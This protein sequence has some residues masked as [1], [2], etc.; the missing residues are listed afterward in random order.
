MGCAK[1]DDFPRKAWR[2]FGKSLT[3]LPYSGFLG[4]GI[5]TNEYFKFLG[6]KIISGEYNTANID[7]LQKIS[8]SKIAPDGHSFSERDW[9][10]IARLVQKKNLFTALT[11][12]A[13]Y[14]GQVDNPRKLRICG[15][16]HLESALEKH[17]AEIGVA[18]FV[19]FEGFVQTDVIAKFLA[20]SLALILP[21]TEEQFGNVVIEAQAMGLPVLISQVCGARDLLVRNWVNGFVFEPDNPEG[22]AGFMAL[23]DRDEILWRKL[24]AGATATA[25][26]GDVARFVEGVDSLL[27]HYK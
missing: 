11:A 25:P 22:L 10:I 20:N 13:I 16:G 4:S 8:Q 9:I 27:G 24:C 5:R 3:L 2:E 15:S 18:D 14:R 1:F 21:S 7:R 6:I 12:Y 19:N 23:L 26:L 17:A